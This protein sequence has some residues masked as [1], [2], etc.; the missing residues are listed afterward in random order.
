MNTVFINCS[1]K[2][3]LSVSGFIGKCAGFPVRGKKEYL[4]PRT[5]ADRAAVLEAL[6]DAD[7]VVFVTPLYVDGLPS[8]ILPLLKEMEASCRENRLHPKVYAIANNGFIEGRQNEPLMRVLEN[9][10]T[11]AGLEWRG[12][13]G[14]GGGVMLNAERLVMTVMFFIMLLNIVLQ[15]VRG[16]NGYPVAEADSGGGRNCDLLLIG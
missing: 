8:H 12:G 11:R 3:K 13:I 2:K 6:K 9:F 1:P 5:P 7:T 10:C 16:G 14:I 4:Q 15:A